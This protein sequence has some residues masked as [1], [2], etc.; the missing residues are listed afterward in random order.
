MPAN[1]KGDKSLNFQRFQEK[2]GDD[3]N[4]MEVSKRHQQQA[5]VDFY[6][7]VCAQNKLKK[8]YKVFGLQA[9]RADLPCQSA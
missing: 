7:T 5:Y 3:N 4:K 1:F 8:G 2:R 6:C 9:R